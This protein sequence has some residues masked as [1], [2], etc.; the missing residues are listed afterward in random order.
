M[1]R[2]RVDSIQLRAEAGVFDSQRDCIGKAAGETASV[3]ASMPSYDGQLSGPARAA[4]MEARS[5]A[6]GIT[7]RLGEQAYQLRK[8][9]D[10]YEAADRT[11]LDWWQESIAWL[12]A[13][14]ENLKNIFVSPPVPLAA[15]PTQTPI[16]NP[17]LAPALTPTP[18]VP[19]TPTLLETT[20]PAPK[21]TPIV[22][23]VLSGETLTSIAEKYGVSV[24]S[25]VAANP[26]IADPNRIFPGQTLQIPGTD[27]EADSTTTP[28]A[29]IGIM[30]SPLRS[31][32]GNGN[33]SSFDKAHPGLDI[34]SKI[35]KILSPFKGEVVSSDKCP[36]CVDKEKYPKNLNGQL[37]PADTNEKDVFKDPDVNFGFG[38]CMILEFKY[39]DLT[40]AQ[41]EDLN[42]RL[43]EGKKLTPG[44]SIYMM[45]AHLDR[46]EEI[47]EAGTKIKP[48]EEIA[49][50]GS[51]GHSSG[52]HL[53]I[54]IAVGDSGQRPATGN[55]AK[56]W[57]AIAGKNSDFPGNRVDPEPIVGAA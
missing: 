50:I 17:A 14:L 33:A 26:N 24:A 3:A 31:L 45:L 13:Q 35:K 29:G 51:T 7:A 49:A 41:L 43:P 16:A 44:K 10:A 36:G 5:R 40:K 53:H 28:A 21:K 25:I 12:N 39:E 54:E 15:V 4:G 38:A 18:T 32:D 27:T 42:A 23:T 52:P 1:P 57:W 34:V 47:P 6:A 46:E 55:T 30:D 20:T 48:A 2:I 37:N 22:H 19:Q 9:A 11:S 8:L 56:D